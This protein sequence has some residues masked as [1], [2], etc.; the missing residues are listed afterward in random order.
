MEYLLD[1]LR[2][3]G[4][5]AAAGDAEWDAMLALAE[6]EHVLPWV[7]ARLRVPGSGLASERLERLAQMERDAGVAAFY[8]SCELRRLLHAFAESGID[9]VP[10][11]G[12]YLA[13]RMYGD[14]ALRGCCDLDVLVAD[15]DLARAEAM[16][17]E[18]GF[19][20]GEADDYHRAWYLRGTVRTTVELHFD[21]ENRLAFNFDVASALARTEA[22]DFQGAACRRLA[23]EDELLFLCLHGVRHRYDRLS[24][25]LDL[26]LAFAA[27]LREREGWHPRAEVRELDGLIALGLAMVRRLDPEFDVRPGLRRLG[28][29]VTCAHAAH[30]EKVADG[31][32]DE[33]MTQTSEPLDWRAVHAFFVELE[34][35]PWARTRRRG[36]HARILASRVIEADTLFAARFGMRRRWQAW[37]LRPVR[38]M[39]EAVQAR[40]ETE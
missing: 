4:V 13:Q 35:S 19:D 23:P 24:L 3:G 39:T 26:R 16:L 11:K 12:P 5:W 9:A 33:L 6:E 7:A 27:L 31:L 10:L 8:W 29:R 21:V 40:R 30:L 37:L 18:M 2:G 20:A 38:M 25:V 15:A 22:G 17:E 34:P 36:R 32:W 14:V 28:L 1:V